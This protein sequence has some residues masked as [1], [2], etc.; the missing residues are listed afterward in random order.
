MSYRAAFFRKQLR[1]L[2]PAAAGGQARLEVADGM[3]HVFQIFAPMMPEAQRALASA[4][5]FLV[6]N[7]R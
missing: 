4:A 1:A 3:W 6:R 2:V 7:S 5:R